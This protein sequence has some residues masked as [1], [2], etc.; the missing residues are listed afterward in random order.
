[1]K[2]MIHLFLFALL[3][4][5]CSKKEDP[6][7][8]F[9][10]T[11]WGGKFIYKGETVNRV[12]VLSLDDRDNFVWEDAG[13]LYPGKWKMAETGGIDITFSANGIQTHFDLNENA[14]AAAKNLNHDH[15][16]IKQ[17]D[18]VALPPSDLDESQWENEQKWQLTFSKLKALQFRKG[19]SNG[20]SI[21]YQL[22]NSAIKGTDGYFNASYK[23][24]FYGVFISEKI[25]IGNVVYAKDLNSKPET[26]ED[27]YTYV[28]Q[29]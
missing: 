9:K 7:V 6:E 16:T 4:A 27:A 10:N 21:T 25:M 12:F 17:M 1:M 28:R 26:V 8:S 11:E 23:A 24:T 15:W 18:K 22:K 29:K 5:G 3:A 19:P 14:M 20:G 2:T 13:G